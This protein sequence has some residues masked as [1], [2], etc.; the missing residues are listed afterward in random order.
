MSFAIRI[1]LPSHTVSN[2]Q[3]SSITAGV[4][5]ATS[6]LSILPGQHAVLNKWGVTNLLDLPTDVMERLLLRALVQA[7]CRTTKGR[8]CECIIIAWPLLR[9]LTSLCQRVAASP[10]G[11]A[12]SAGR[13]KT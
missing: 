13:P 11:E 3:C 7:E 12:A 8:R 2:L 5:H 10:S 4:L 6:V 9:S 1:L